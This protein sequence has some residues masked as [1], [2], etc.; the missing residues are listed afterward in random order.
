[1]ASSTGK[2]ATKADKQSQGSLALKEKGR[3]K[4]RTPPGPLSSPPPSVER[5]KAELASKL[6][7]P[8]ERDKE[9]E[10]LDQMLSTLDEDEAKNA[11]RRKAIRE[12]FIAKSEEGRQSFVK[13]VYNRFSPH[14]D[15]YMEETGHYPAIRRL[16]RKEVSVHTFHFPA[17]DISA[18]TAVPLEFFLG[19][20]NK[21]H[22]I[23]ESPINFIKPD[24]KGPLIYVN[25]LADKMIVQAE[26]RLEMLKKNLETEAENLGLSA[27]PLFADFSN[28]NPM[29]YKNYSFRNLHSSLK[30]RFGTIIVSQT[31]HI[32]GYK[33]KENLARAINWALA[34]G[35]RVILLEEFDW[36][37]SPKLTKQAPPSVIRV[38]GA[39]ASPIKT[40]KELI[41]LFK[42]SDG[43]PYDMVARSIE[44]IDREDPGHEMTITIL[45]KPSPGN[46]TIP[47]WF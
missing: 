41:M 16:L 11:D 38:V 6:M 25:D 45:Q 4:A 43:V 17:L 10:E 39:I 24:Y 3:K 12:R 29:V 1:M 36:K 15:H 21:K 9:D 14:Y 40:K 20:V 23:E 27:P 5:K 28:G 33:D 34:P 46:P 19:E 31:F 13:K 26:V 18:G 44:R 7:E 30:R 47:L 35:G 42:D 2:E 37:A 22:L 8:E 32:V